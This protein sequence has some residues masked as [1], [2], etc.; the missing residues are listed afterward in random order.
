[1]TADLRLPA[2]LAPGDLD[3]ARARPAA[4][5]V[6]RL[7]TRTLFGYRA[8]PGLRDWQAVEPVGDLAAMV[9][10]TYNAGLGASLR[11]YV[12]HLRQGVRWDTTPPRPVTAH[13][14][15]RGFTRVCAPTAR[16]AGIE[17]L[18]SLVRGMRAYAERYAEAVAGHEHDVEWHWA[19]QAADSIPGV[20]AL[21]AESLVVE[22]EQPAQDAVDVLALP[23]VAPAPVEYDDFVPGTADFLRHARATGPYRIAEVAPDGGIRLE[24]NPVWDPATDPLRQ[25]VFG[26]VTLRTDA[27]A[28]DLRPE[29][30]VPEVLRACLLPNAAPGR[31]LADPARRRLVASAVDPEVVAA[32]LPGARAATRVIPPGNSAGPA[33]ARPGFRPADVTAGDLVLVHLNDAVVAEAVAGC[34]SRAGFQVTVREVT[35]AQHAE[36]LYGRSDLEPDLVL[37]SWAARWRHHNYRAYLQPLLTRSVD[38]PVFDVLI[39]QALRADSDPNATRAAW[40]AV[41]RE[42]LERAA[43]IPLLHGP[44]SAARALPGMGPVTP[45]YSLGLAADPANLALPV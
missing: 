34:L 44:P 12:V 6:H 22:L 33:P 38:R 37:T 16:P 43:V 24:P 20:F 26:T 35:A 25:R 45:L 7:T 23:C 30:D 41:E 15:V 42:A 3:P 4:E 10:S 14:V 29:A 39:E 17:S 36:L 5:L 27:P 1:M 40:A 2:P 8:G 31:P 18:L 21:D 28:P 9:P 19:F 11:S 13:D 32:H